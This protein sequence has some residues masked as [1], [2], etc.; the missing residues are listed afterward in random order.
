M[1]RVSWLTWSHCN[2]EAACDQRTGTG[3]EPVTGMLPAL[4][5]LFDVSRGRNLNPCRTC[6][7]TQFNVRLSSVPRVDE[8]KT[9]GQW[10]KIW[11]GDLAYLFFSSFF[12][13]ASV[14]T[15]DV[16]FIMSPVMRC[17]NP[18]KRWEISRAIPFF[19]SILIA[20]KKA[21]NSRRR[22]PERYP[23]IPK[24]PIVEKAK[25]NLKC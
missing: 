6:H 7:F 5:L 16:E 12:K 17:Q 19:F 11:A 1:K 24:T 15:S 20:D 10:D 18:V 4:G 21:K 13:W 9:Y 23:I 22:I 2:N 14:K 25:G 3:P 8:P